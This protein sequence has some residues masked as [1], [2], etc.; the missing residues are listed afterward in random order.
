MLVANCARAFAK[1]ILSSRHQGAIRL[2]ISLLQAAVPLMTL[3]WICSR[4]QCALLLVA[5]GIT[6]VCPCYRLLL[7]KADVI[8]TE[9]YEMATGGFVRMKQFLDA[10]SVGAGYPNTGIAA[11]DSGEVYSIAGVTSQTVQSTDSIYR[12]SVGLDWFERGT[13]RC[14]EVRLLHRL[15]S[16]DVGLLTLKTCPASCPAIAAIILCTHS[17][18][19]SLCSMGC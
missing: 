4:L 11:V 5:A 3:S 10:H 2:S 8:I 19:I 7:L 6:H 9:D 13:S 18:Q 12:G 14:D 17:A 1:Q 15:H 16:V